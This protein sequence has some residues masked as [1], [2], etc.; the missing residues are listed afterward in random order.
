MKEQIRPMG[1]RLF[2]GLRLRMSLA[3]GFLEQA[4]IV[5]QYR[6]QGCQCGGK[7]HRN[8]G[9]WIGIQHL[10]RGVGQSADN[11]KTQGDGAHV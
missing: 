1:C 5:D 3:C 8:D 9:G 2:G 4:Q 7:Q 10:W 6:R 11:G